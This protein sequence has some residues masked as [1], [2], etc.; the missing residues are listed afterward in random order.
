MVETYAFPCQPDMTSQ[1][2]ATGRKGVSP[3]YLHKG[4]MLFHAGAIAPL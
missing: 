4:A 2:M 3:D 1:A